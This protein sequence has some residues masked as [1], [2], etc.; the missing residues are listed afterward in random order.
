MLGTV[1]ISVVCVHP[2]DFRLS[3]AVSSLRVHF[4]KHWPVR[5]LEEEKILTQCIPNACQSHVTQC[6]PIS[7]RAD[8]PLPVTSCIS[9]HKLWSVGMSSSRKEDLPRASCAPCFSHSRLLL[10][11]MASTRPGHPPEVRRWCNDLLMVH[12]SGIYHSGIGPV[13]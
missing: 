8:C 10:F 11:A 3:I 6:M 4:M 2:K 1:V 12:V 5:K 7:W 13:S 9:N